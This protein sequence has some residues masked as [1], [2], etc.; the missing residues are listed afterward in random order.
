MP[1]ELAYGPGLIGAPVSIIRSEWDQ[2]S[3]EED[4]KCLFGALRSSPIRRIV[5]TSRGSHLMHLEAS[6]RALYRET[7]TFLTGDVAAIHRRDAA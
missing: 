5:T 1:L 3:S 2:M 6:R 7:E 4:V